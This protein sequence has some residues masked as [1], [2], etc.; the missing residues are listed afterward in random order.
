MNGK[1]LNETINRRVGDPV[2]DEGLVDF[3]K[4]TVRWATKGAIDLA[5]EAGPGSVQPETFPLSVPG[6]C[7]F[8]IGAIQ[9]HARL[10]GLLIPEEMVP[11][12]R[13]VQEAYRDGMTERYSGEEAEGAGYARSAWDSRTGGTT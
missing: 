13:D 11:F 10:S 6:K 4:T 9:G 2:L 1:M 12:L 5:E 3:L 7:A 8:L